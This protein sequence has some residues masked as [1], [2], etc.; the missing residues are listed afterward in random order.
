[1]STMRRPRRHCAFVG[2]GLPPEARIGSLMVLSDK[3]QFEGLTRPR[4]GPRRPP[5]TVTARTTPRRPV[6]AKPTPRDGV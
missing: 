1:M 4:L 6:A 5:S 3:P 2:Q